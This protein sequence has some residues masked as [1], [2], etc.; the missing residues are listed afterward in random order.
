MEYQI[1]SGNGW[2][3]DTAVRELEKKVQNL[4]KEGW[5]PIGGMVIASFNENAY[6]TLI[7][8]SSDNK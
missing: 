7:R 2:T 8:R 3:P 4:L 1:V 5:E 6:Q